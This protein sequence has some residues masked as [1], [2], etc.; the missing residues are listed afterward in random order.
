MLTYTATVTN[1]GPATATK[2]VLSEILPNGIGFVSASATSGTLSTTGGGIA[3]YDLPFT[4]IP[5]GFPSDLPLEESGNAVTQN[6]LAAAHTNA[7]DFRFQSTRV[8]YTTRSLD[9]GILI[10]RNYSVMCDR[11]R[12]LTTTRRIAGSNC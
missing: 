3:T 7:D 12:R 8:F 11:C 4:R 1:S 9:D 10:Y 5:D 2:S 6:Y